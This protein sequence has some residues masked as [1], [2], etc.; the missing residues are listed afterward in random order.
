MI[1]RPATTGDG[2]AIADLAIQ[3]GYPTSA[4]QAGARLRNLE[5]SSEHGVYVAEDDMGKVVGWVHVFG[6]HRLIVAPFAE[7][8]GLVVDSARRS[9]GIGKALLQAAETWA[10]ANGYQEMRIRS[11]TIRSAAHQFYTRLGYETN[12]TQHV[13][14]KTLDEH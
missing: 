5:A 6:A 13:L 8:G 9:E 7:V 12:K 3:L 14:L 10:R 11:N 1:I 4:E 2:E